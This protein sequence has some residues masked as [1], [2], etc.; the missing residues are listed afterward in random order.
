MKRS[1][2]A[3]RLIEARNNGERKRLLTANL[4][5]ADAQL[6][7]ELKDHCYRVWTSEPTGAQKAARALNTLVKFSADDETKAVRAWVEGIADITRG[8]LESAV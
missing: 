4:G 7:R 6:A 8:R 2:L 1:T 3:S 5:L